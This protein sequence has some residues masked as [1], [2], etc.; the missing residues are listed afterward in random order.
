LEY[1]LVK[2]EI[3]LSVSWIFRVNKREFTWDARKV[4]SWWDIDQKLKIS[5][6][7]KLRACNLFILTQKKILIMC[8]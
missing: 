7:G 2:P 8:F 3:V 5:F 4:L 1:N 6:A